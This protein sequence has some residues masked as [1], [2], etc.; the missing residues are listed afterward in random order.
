MKKDKWV[1]V[2][3]VY[4]VLY[5]LI[6]H[7]KSLWILFFYSKNKLDMGCYKYEG[8]FCKE[9]IKRNDNDFISNVYKIIL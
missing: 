8:L 2:G 5:V 4:Y 9:R 7:K 1:F 3:N 6:N